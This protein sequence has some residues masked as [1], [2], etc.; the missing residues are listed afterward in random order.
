[1]QSESKGHGFESLL[2]TTHDDVYIFNLWNG[3]FHESELLLASMTS[4]GHVRDVPDSINE[5]NLDCAKS[6][7]NEWIHFA[8]L[9]QMKKVL[10][11]GSLIH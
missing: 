7:N 3:K 10:T 8:S 1:M 2:K 6:K 9:V 11:M 4:V 5:K